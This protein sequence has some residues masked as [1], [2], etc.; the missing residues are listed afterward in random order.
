KDNSKKRNSAEH[1]SMMARAGAGDSETVEQLEKLMAKNRNSDQKQEL[2]RGSL[3][4]DNMMSNDDSV[5]IKDDFAGYDDTTTSAKWYFKYTFRSECHKCSILSM[6]MSSTGEQFFTADLNGIICVW[7]VPSSNAEAHENYDPQILAEKF[8]GHS[9]AIWGL[10]YQS[11][12]NRLISASADKT[13]KI[14]ELGSG[15]DALIHTYTETDIGSPLTIDM[16]AAEPQQI[17][18]GYKNQ[19]A[20]IFDIEVGRTVLQFESNPDDEGQISKILSHPTMPVTI[21][22]GSDRRIRYFDNNSGK[23]IHSTVAHVE[24]ISTLAI[25]PN[26]LYLLSGCHDGSLRLWNMEKRTCLQEIAAHRK[27]FDMSVMS[28]AFHPSRPIIGS[29]G[30]DSLAKIYTSQKSSLSSSSGSDNRVV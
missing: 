20:F 26:G 1:A 11:S 15:S 19:C 16:V 12:S 10:C 4:L 21:A 30:A 7:N 9:N 14:W 18:A 28:V 2:D 23:L 17:V 25:D 13:L 6:D 29:A 8:N 3:E 22:A 24:S 5:D 27:K